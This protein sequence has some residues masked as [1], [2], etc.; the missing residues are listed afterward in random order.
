MHDRLGL[1]PG[2][3]VHD[4]G[5]RLL[6]VPNADDPRVFFQVELLR[7]CCK[8]LIQ[9]SECSRRSSE[10]IRKRARQVG[11]THPMCFR[12][13][14]IRGPKPLMPILY[15]VRCES[16]RWYVQGE[17]CACTIGGDERFRADQNPWL[18]A[19]ECCRVD[20]SKFCFADNYA[21]YGGGGTGSGL[22]VDPVDDEATARISHRSDVFG[23]FVGTVL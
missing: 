1:I 10:S 13:R 5:Q 12:P 9:R 14:S 21:T 4:S 3:S 17:K 23:K 22:F 15:K 7:Y 16:A 8:V 19:R 6:P 20:P 2:R 18:D 11:L